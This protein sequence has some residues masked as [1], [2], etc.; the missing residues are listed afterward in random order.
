MEITDQKISYF[1]IQ[2]VKVGQILNQAQFVVPEERDRVSDEL[3]L[4]EMGQP[5]DWLNLQKIS[6]LVLTQIEPF[7]GK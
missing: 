4:L 3:E 5:E 1:A 6:Q 7:Q 2:R